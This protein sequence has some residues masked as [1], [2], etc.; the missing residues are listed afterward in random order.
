M[1]CV[2]LF[3]LL[4]KHTVTFRN[5]DLSDNFIDHLD[6]TS[7]PTSQLTSLN[8]ARNRVQILPDN[9]FVSL[10]KLLVL[11]I[12]QNHL[13][14][15][16][17]EVF[18]YLPDL[19]KLSLANCEFKNI[20]HLQLASL[21]YLDLSHNNIETL[22]ESE[23]QNFRALK[24][25]L[26]T[27]NSLSSISGFKL[28]LLRELDISGNPIKVILLLTKSIWNHIAF[29]YTTVLTFPTAQDRDLMKYLQLIF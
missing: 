17:K 2:S 13:R 23:L 16:F 10:A 15:N 14:T 11:N 21:N 7:F 27:N 8:L 18:H 24:I 4:L 20:P 5:I 19:R 12:S 6:A 1:D 3:F 28:G 25:L 26:L 29:Q 22:R 9:S